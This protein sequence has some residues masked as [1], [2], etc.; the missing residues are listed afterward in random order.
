MV[1]APEVME[2][3]RGVLEL[4]AEGKPECEVVVYEGATHGFAVRWDPKSERQQRQGE[5]AE[6]QAV[7]WFLKHFAAK[8]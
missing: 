8:G 2:E 4:S 6:E 5:E 3:V 1:I 7:R